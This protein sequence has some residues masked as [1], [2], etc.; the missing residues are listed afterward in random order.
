MYVVEKMFSKLINIGITKK[1]EQ[2]LVP[3]LQRANINGFVF[4]VLDTALGIFFFT[5]TK[6]NYLGQLLLAAGISFALGSLGLNFLGLHTLSR[7]S[8][9][10][11]GSILV[12][13]CALYLGPQSNV[14]L[15]LL[16]GCIFP[17][18]YFNPTE[19]KSIF[20]CLSVP[21]ICYLSL[22]YLDFQSSAPFHFS[23]ERQLHQLQFIFFIVPFIGIVMNAY[24]A[25]TLL[26]A[27]AKSI[28][29]SQN[30]L[31]T[32]FRALSHD[33]ANPM[34]TINYIAS[35]AEMKNQLTDSQLKKLVKSN[36]QLV[37]MFNH[38]KRIAFVSGGKQALETQTF[39]LNEFLK[40]CSTHFKELC[41]QKNI[42]LILD[43]KLP[44]TL[45]V[46]L[47]LQ[48]FRYQILQNL[49]TNAIK[50]S[51]PNSQIHLKTGLDQN[52]QVYVQVCDQGQGI[53]EEKLNQIFSWN[54]AA[55]SIGTQ[56]EK[57]TGLGLPL[58]KRFTE[59]MQIEFNVQSRSI[60]VNTLHHGTEMILILP[61][62][63]VSN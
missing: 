14:L 33:L 6:D 12:T 51:F 15:S 52:G 34:T 27:K 55:S 60:E 28:E 44:E 58:V 29:E 38:L 23:S 16:L 50:F 46:N 19:K 20:L 3:Y 2:Q 42:E 25:V 54:T 35:I 1:T 36:K 47:D 24:Q 7:L 22:I 49:I 41:A 56:G 30:H 61:E 39:Q 13:L 45:T 31:Q 63:A 26:E 62:H 11:I 9:V 53:R 5:V 8:T 18:V 17:F 43:S 40:E 10:S 57:G 32:I 59:L 37:D 4:F 21:I 48:V